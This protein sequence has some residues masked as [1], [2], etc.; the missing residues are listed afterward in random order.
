MFSW[1]KKQKKLPDVLSSLLRRLGFIAGPSVLA[2]AVIY[3]SLIVSLK[4]GIATRYGIG[5]FTAQGLDIASVIAPLWWWPIAL[6]FVL[7]VTGALLAARKKELR[8]L[9]VLFLAIILARPSYMVTLSWSGGPY[10]SIGDLGWLETFILSTMGSISIF[11]FLKILRQHLTRLH[12]FRVRTTVVL[13]LIIIAFAPLLNNNLQQA[14]SGYT[15]QNYTFHPGFN[16][17][18]AFPAHQWILAHTK[19]SDV[20][21]AEV[22]NSEIFAAGTGRKVVVVMPGHISP[23]AN[24]TQRALDVQ[25]VLDHSNASLMIRVIEKYGVSYVIVYSFQAHAFLD[26]GFIAEGKELTF[27][28]LYQDASY[29]VLG[30]KIV[31]L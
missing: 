27:T 5:Y 29:A 10:G 11:M 20:I 28:L 4:S 19:T 26:V 16:W 30:P 22:A 3:P 7:A 6:L 23:L 15:A 24:Y 25:G 21:L 17:L 9:V 14:M 18:P 12:L 1:Q 13:M 31:S 2:G 8:V